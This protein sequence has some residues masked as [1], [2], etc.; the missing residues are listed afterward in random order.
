[1]SNRKKKE[2]R[3]TDPSTKKGISSPIAVLG[4]GM[5]GTALALT[6]ARNDNAVRLWTNEPDVAE[7]VRQ[8]NCNRKYL[9]DHPFLK[10]ISIYE[11]LAEALIGVTDILLVVPSYAF[12]AVCL[13]IK[14]AAKNPVRIAWGTKGVDSDTNK[15]LSDVIAEVFSA[16]L[17]M[18]AMSGPSFAKEVADALPTAVSCSGNNDAFLDDMITRFHHGN[19]RVYKNP[20]FIGVQLCG[21]VKNVLAIAVGMSDG[22]GFGAN[23]RCALITR[24]LAEMTRLCVAMG[25]QEKTLMSLAGVGDLVLTCTDNQSRNRRF[26]LA[27]GQGISAD[28]ALKQIG[29]SVEGYANTKQ[30]YQLSKKYH[31]DMPITEH[32]MKI[33]F[34]NE[35]VK[36]VVKQLLERS[37]KPEF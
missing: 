10:N 13:E 8:E 12:R 1:M 21:A 5:W 24:G 2:S 31:I 18:V 26:G 30:I 17:P 37:L 34:E 35:P 36:I 14:S 29:Q 7:S 27:L 20:D 23:T 11:N 33:L 28:V 3:V 19:F 4:A 9:P 32:V 6:L 22:I 25:G 15:L 16:D